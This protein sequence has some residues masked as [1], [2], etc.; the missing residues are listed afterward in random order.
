[1]SK[2]LPTHSLPTELLP[3]KDMA[4]STLLNGIGN[5]ITV[6]SI[7]LAVGS[8]LELLRITKPLSHDM[9]VAG[10]VMMMTGAAIGAYYGTREA[11]HLTEYQLALAQ[12]LTDLRTHITRGETQVERLAERE[13]ARDAADA[14]ARG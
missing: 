8:T 11:K 13:N 9:K 14:K 12:E 10:A 5:G 4:M 2:D 1:M 3:P 7:P 6:G